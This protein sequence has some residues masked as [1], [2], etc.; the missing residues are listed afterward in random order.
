MA[1]GSGTSGSG[2][3]S[4]GAAGTSGLLR[5]A[6]LDC[7]ARGAFGLLRVTGE[8]GGTVYLD[9]GNVTAIDT[10]G[11][12]GPE[13]IL[14]RSGRIAEPAWTAAF[15]AGAA[16]GR[17]SAELVQRGLVGA[18][19]LEALLRV[20]LADAMFALAA[21]RVDGCDIAE[22]AAG[23]DY[24]LPLTPPVASSWLISELSIWT[25][26]EASLISQLEATGGV[27]GSR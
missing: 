17:M 21:G 25:R 27:S 7:A 19:E 20:A 6:L 5:E 8:P 1:D 9:G 14:L 13:V 24:L 3:A 11:A 12:P 23:P 10:P 16:A 2:A 4:S 18:G 22:R 15:A 26:R